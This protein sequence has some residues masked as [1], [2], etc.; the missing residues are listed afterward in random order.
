[1]KQS[2]GGTSDIHD[3]VARYFL[4]VNRMVRVPS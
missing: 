4:L 3:M 1:M 2:F